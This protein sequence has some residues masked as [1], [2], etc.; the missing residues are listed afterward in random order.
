[1]DHIKRK[2]EIQCIKL[3][4]TNQDIRDDIK[5]CLRDY[6]STTG[7]KYIEQSILY[8]NATRTFLQCMNKKTI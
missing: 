4:T 2:K 6:G 8:Q 1:M 7:C 3:C 5:F